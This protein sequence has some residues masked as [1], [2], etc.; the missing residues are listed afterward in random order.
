MPLLF[1]AASPSA[2]YF[3]RAAFGTKHQHGFPHADA[4]HVQ[5][6]RLFC[7]LLMRFRQ[8]RCAEQPLLLVVEQHERNLLRLFRRE[9]FHQRQH[10]AHARR[11]V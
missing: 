10:P 1:R 4:V 2:G 7:H 6:K 8:P 3:S 9:R 11:V 5:H